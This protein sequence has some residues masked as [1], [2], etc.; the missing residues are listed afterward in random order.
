[1]IGAP[2]PLDR[3][4]DE[5]RRLRQFEDEW[6]AG[7]TPELAAYLPRLS[8]R[9]Q[10]D[11]AQRDLVVELIAI[12]LEYRLRRKNEVSLED[13]CRRYAL[14]SAASLPLELIAAEYEAQCLAG[15]PP[16]FEA[17]VARF[18]GRAESLRPLL[19][20]RYK[21]SIPIAERDED[22]ASLAA[23]FTDAPPTAIASVLQALDIVEPDI[24]RQLRTPCIR[25]YATAAD[26][27]AFA[28]GQ[29]WLTR[30]Q[31]EQLLARRQQLMQGPM[32]ASRYRRRG[33]SK[34]FWPGIGCC[35]VTSR[36]R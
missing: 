7:T 12:D 28:V 21:E 2:G 36:T 20:K 10:D 9:W 22:T 14:G 33:L 30:F 27:L 32:F 24:A 17:F 35:I 19:A 1:M 16:D 4:S 15:I 6:K 34:S 23:T 18:P 25:R 3:H 11:P 31:A 26:L 13:Y 5:E 29:A 8:Q